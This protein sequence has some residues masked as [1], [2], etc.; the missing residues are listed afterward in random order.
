MLFLIDGYNL[1]HAVGW[2]TPRMAK[3]SLEPARRK[4][5]D[6]LVDTVAFRV[7]GAK[8]RVVF[9][10]QKGPSHIP[11]ET[12][13]RGVFVSY[14][15][16]STADD[17]IEELLAGASKPGEV[18]VVSNDTRLHESARVVKAQGWSSRKFLDWLN[19]R[20]EAAKPPEAE[21]APEKPTGPPTPEE[22]AT[23]IAAFEIRHQKHNHIK[24]I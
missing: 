11:R 24:R 19:A 6:W 23:L 3:S 4:L 1:L 22:A 9:D 14:A 13:H 5:L 18:V 12:S 21:T 15:W 20:E 2:A 7:D 10:A 16:R 8:F 17:L